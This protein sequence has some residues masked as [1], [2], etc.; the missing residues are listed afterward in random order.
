MWADF[1]NN[2]DALNRLSRLILAAALLF[3]GW[4]VGKSV[5]ENLFPFRQVTVLGANHADTQTAAREMVRK[6]SGGFFSMDLNRV[7]RDFAALP[8]VRQA[9][10]RRLWP[11]RLVV[12]LSEHQAA[13]AWND[14]ATLDV[15]GEIFPVL[16]WTGLPRIY[17]PDGME[18]EVTRRYGE[19]S[20]LVKPIGMQVEQIVVS[21]RLSWRVRLSSRAPSHSADDSAVSADGAERMAAPALSHDI[22]VEL[23]RERQTERLDRFARFYPQAVAAVGAIH[24]FDMR[25]PNGFAGEV[26]HPAQRPG[27]HPAP[28]N[29]TTRQAKPA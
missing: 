13:A 8:W 23:G 25:Y 10:V 11:G 19:F 26:Q 27:P 29:T 9:Q 3:A 28:L 22:N 16:P 17:A 2:P 6:L 20:A 18:R 4:L 15:H 12:E 14:R 7:H 1:W 21:A 24:R 5:L